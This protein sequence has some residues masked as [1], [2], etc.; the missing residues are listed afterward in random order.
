[1]VAVW[2]LTLI[3]GLPLLIAKIK[4]DPIKL[5]LLLGVMSPKTRLPTVRAISFVTVESTFRF[6][7]LK[8]AS[9]STPLGVPPDQFAATPQ[10][11]LAFPPTKFVHVDPDT[12]KANNNVTPNKNKPTQFHMNTAIVQFEHPLWQGGQAE[13]EVFTVCIN[14]TYFSCIFLDALELNAGTP[15]LACPRCLNVAF[16]ILATQCG[17][18]QDN[19]DHD[20][21]TAPDSGRTSSAGP[22]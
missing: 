18:P 6:N 4:F 14:F 11:P 19:H 21:F 8:S 5:Q 10:V 12:L 7:V 22:D 9:A 3:I 15:K 20:L 16:D 1:M 17:S 2:L 13:L